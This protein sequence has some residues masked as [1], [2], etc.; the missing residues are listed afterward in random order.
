[1]IFKLH[2]KKANTQAYLIESLSCLI[3]ISLQGKTGYG[4]SGAERAFSLHA[5]EVNAVPYGGQRRTDGE[6]NKVQQI[7]RIEGTLCPECHI[8]TPRFLRQDEIL[9]IWESRNPETS[10]LFLE[11]GQVTQVR[12]GQVR[13]GWS[14]LG[15]VRL[16][17]VRL[18]W[19]R[20]GQV[21]VGQVRFEKV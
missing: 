12:L 21:G 3:L 16:G 2:E 17:Q 18:G 4:N 6:S 20:L 15:Q 9:G 19:G 5:V 8:R 1:M 10:H 7:L 13:L 11:L 14:R